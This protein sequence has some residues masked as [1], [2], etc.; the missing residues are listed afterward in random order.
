MHLDTFF[1][2]VSDKVKDLQLGP[3]RNVRQVCFT[4]YLGL[5][6]GLFGIFTYDEKV[7]QKLLLDLTR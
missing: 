2:L 1:C 7:F 5:F 4:F 6:D 3:C